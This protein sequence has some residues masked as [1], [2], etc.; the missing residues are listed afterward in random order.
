MSRFTKLWLEKGILKSLDTSLVSE[1]IALLPMQA[2]SCKIA[3]EIAI[4]LSPD[5]FSENLRK[6]DFH[7]STTLQ[8][9]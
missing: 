9:S 7:I 2:F 3:I 4:E 1:F 8:I 5:E 6:L